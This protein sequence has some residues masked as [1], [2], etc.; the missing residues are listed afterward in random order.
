M[1]YRILLSKQDILM[2]TPNKIGSGSADFP[3]RMSA[4]SP[5]GAVPVCGCMGETRG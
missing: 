3:A 5:A 2:A 4:Y 1:M